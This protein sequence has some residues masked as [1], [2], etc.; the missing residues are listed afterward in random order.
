MKLL[1]L[2]HFCSLV[3]QDKVLRLELELATA[4]D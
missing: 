3:F 2:E 4:S 1:M